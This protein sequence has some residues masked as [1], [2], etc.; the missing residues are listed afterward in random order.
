MLVP[1]RSRTRRV[2]L[3]LSA[4]LRGGSAGSCRTRLVP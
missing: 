3:S 2:V 1:S 4:Q